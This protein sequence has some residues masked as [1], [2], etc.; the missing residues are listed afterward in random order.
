LPKHVEFVTHE[1]PKTAVGK[2]DWRTMQERDKLTELPYGDSE[3]SGNTV[4]G[5]N[6]DLD[7]EQA[8]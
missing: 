8:S 1:L 4:S 7:M 5:I 3:I 6:D 2:P